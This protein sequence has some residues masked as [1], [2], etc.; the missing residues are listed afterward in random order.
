MFHF[1]LGSDKEA[2]EKD[3]KDD[4]KPVHEEPEDQKVEKED[5]KSKNESET[6]DEKPSN[7]T[8]KE[9]KKEKEKKATPVV[10]KEPIETNQVLLGP[11]VDLENLDAS[12]KK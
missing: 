7:Q 6:K 11:T 8:E 5:A 10:M 4:V 9:D 12:R 1:N 3:G 2:T